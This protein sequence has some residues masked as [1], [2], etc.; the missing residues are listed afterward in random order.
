[1]VHL[2]FNGAKQKRLELKLAF[3][4]GEAKKIVLFNGAKQKKI[5]IKTGKAKKRLGQSS[6]EPSPKK[7]APKF[8]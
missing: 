6:W 4:D 3:N 2:Q 1:M 7:I 5:R 8:S